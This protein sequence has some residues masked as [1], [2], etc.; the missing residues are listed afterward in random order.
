MTICVVEDWIKEKERTELLLWKQPNTVKLLHCMQILN[1]MKSTN[2][3]K[4]RW[5][6]NTLSNRANFT[7]DATIRN[8]HTEVQS[9]RTKNLMSS[10]E[11]WDFSM[12]H[13]YFMLD[14]RA[15][16]ALCVYVANFCFNVLI[17]SFSRFRF[18]IFH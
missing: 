2:E 4:E 9:Q 8:V 6:K 15:H 13:V 10:F 12:F 5:N 14:E 11:T 7:R 18:S 3:N 16:R 1:G 17:R